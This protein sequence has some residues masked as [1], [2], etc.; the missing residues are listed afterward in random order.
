MILNVD[1]SSLGNPDVSGFCGLIRNIDGAWVHE[2][3]GNIEYS[4]ILHVELMS[5]YHDLRMAG[6]LDIKGLMCYS[7]SNSAIKLISES[8]NIWYHYVAILHNIK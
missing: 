5:L 2:F 8:V 4:N 7:D 3:A 6:E 1:G